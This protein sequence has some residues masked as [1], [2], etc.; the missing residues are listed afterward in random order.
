MA[1]VR[2]SMLGPTDTFWPQ[3]PPPPPVRVILILT[4]HIIVIVIVGWMQA[5]ARSRSWVTSRSCR[6]PAATRTTT[7]ALNW[8]TTARR[9]TP[10]SFPPTRSTSTTFISSTTAFQTRPTTTASALFRT[11]SWTRPIPRDTCLH[12]R[13]TVPVSTARTASA[14]ASRVRHVE[15]LLRLPSL[16]VVLVVILVS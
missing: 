14:F 9:S 16:R 6:T 3:V 15:F 8:R 1:L 2:F 7:T 5:S 4:Y 10:P 13:R 11:Q 12:R